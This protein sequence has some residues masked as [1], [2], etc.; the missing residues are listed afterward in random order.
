MH[1]KTHKLLQETSCY[2]SVHD[3]KLFYSILFCRQVVFAVVVTSLEQAGN[4]L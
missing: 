3:N 4:N 1:V 2:K